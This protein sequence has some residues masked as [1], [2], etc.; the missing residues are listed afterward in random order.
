MQAYALA[1]EEISSEIERLRAWRFRK[2]AEH[3]RRIDKTSMFSATACRERYNTLVTGDAVIPSALDDDPDAR[4]AQMEAY[5][6]TREAIRFR[7]Q[8]QEEA[9]Q[10]LDQQCKDKTKARM[11]IKAQELIDQRVAKE[12]EKAERARL[13]AK[14][15]AARMERALAMRDASLAK[16]AKFKQHQEDQI[17]ISKRGRVPIQRK[18]R[19]DND[20]AIA[21]P[22]AFDDNNNDNDNDDEDSLPADPRALLSPTDLRRICATEGLDVAG[23]T[24][25]AMLTELRAK[26]D[27]YLMNELRARCVAAGLNGG[28]SKMQ[29]KYRL[30]LAAAHGCAS[31]DTGRKVGGK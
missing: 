30:A 10:A 23:K 11:A 6:D 14:E 17:K 21:I 26:E 12:T 2:V 15:A 20:P 18:V 25:G 16:N 5:R 8:G 4:V 28:G 13:R 27:K 3:M 24:P 7:E 31:Y 9:R 29:M 1:D 19:F 22:T